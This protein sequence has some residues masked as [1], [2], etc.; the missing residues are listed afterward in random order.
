MSEVEHGLEL[1]LQ[2]AQEYRRLH[3]E[4][5]SKQADDEMGNAADVI[6]DHSIKTAL[7]ARESGD[8]TV[9][10]V[11]ATTYLSSSPY[12]RVLLPTLQ[13]SIDGFN[14]VTTFREAGQQHDVLYLL[15]YENDV[16]MIT[17]FVESLA[18]Q[19]VG[20]VEYRW[21]QDPR[22]GNVS[23]H[24]SYRVK[25]EWIQTTGNNIGELVAKTTFRWRSDK[26]VPALMAARL[27]WLQQRYDPRTF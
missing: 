14:L 15:G 21:L 23:L 3:T 19:I 2:R 10:K 26:V 16:H 9:G 1:I 22:Q 6:V 13:R 25:R 18:S 27:Q 17:R 11:D 12:R 24:E 20:D 5:G 7:A 8:R 4:S